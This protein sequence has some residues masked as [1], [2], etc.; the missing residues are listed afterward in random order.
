MSPE[1]KL[2]SEFVRRV[3]NVPDES[4]TYPVVYQP[5][6]SRFAPHF[7]SSITLDMSGIDPA[8]EIQR[9]VY[10]LD[11]GHERTIYLAQDGVGFGSTGSVG[12]HVRLH[13]P[14]RKPGEWKRY[15][16]RR[17]RDPRLAN[18]N[19]HIGWRRR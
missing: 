16:T 7:P 8:N 11:E 13:E 19:P 17:F 2:A 18:T 1:I 3:I 12:V 14:I 5:R 6:L 9:L 10:S 4:G 15:R